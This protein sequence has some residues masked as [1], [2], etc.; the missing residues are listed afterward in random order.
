MSRPSNEKIVEFMW[1]L[2]ALQKKHDLWFEANEDAPLFVSNDEM[3]GEIKMFWENPLKK[4]EPVEHLI[5]IL[6]PER[7][8]TE[9]ESET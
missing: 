6:E 8:T 1:D 3:D 7:L 9:V 5:A 2:Q 4:D